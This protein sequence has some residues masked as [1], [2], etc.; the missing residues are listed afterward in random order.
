MGERQIED[1][2]TE[3]AYDMRELLQ[4]AYQMIKLDIDR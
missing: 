2:V 3:L 1:V 4:F